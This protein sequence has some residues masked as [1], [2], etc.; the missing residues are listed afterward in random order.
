M[1]SDNEI[2]LHVFLWV[3]Q[4]CWIL[5][6]IGFIIAK[7]ST[8]CRTC[9]TPVFQ[10]RQRLGMFQSWEYLHHQRV[11]F[12]S[13][14]SDGDTAMRSHC[15]LLN[16]VL[17]VWHT[18]DGCEIL[19]QL[20]DGLSMFIP[21]FIGFQPSKVVQDFF[22]PQ[23]VHIYVFPTVC[24]QLVLRKKGPPLKSL[25]AGCFDRRNAT[26]CGAF[27]PSSQWGLWKNDGSR[28]FSM[29]RWIDGSLRMLHFVALCCAYHN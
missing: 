5:C 13:F 15:V 29:D 4:Y 21:L 12:S 7:L 10:L 20:I 24:F 2:V 26:L 18:V 14:L 23:Y 25:P 19:H 8:A 17:L 22:H 3:L 16:V 1:N 9:F 11:P 28:W 6:P 27:G